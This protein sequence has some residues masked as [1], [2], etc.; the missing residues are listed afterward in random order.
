MLHSCATLKPAHWPADYKPRI[1]TSS[2]IKSNGGYPPAAPLRGGGTLWIKR[3]SVK[4]NR[5]ASQPSFIRSQATVPLFHL[6]E[7]TDDHRHCLLS[8]A[9]GAR[10][11]LSPPTALFGA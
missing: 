2:P 3:V 8:L 5:R 6:A 11:R 4:R 10:A 1:G 7:R 9:P